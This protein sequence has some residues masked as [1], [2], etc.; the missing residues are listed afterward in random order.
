MLI[1]I[2]IHGV[3]YTRCRI[4]AHEYLIVSFDCLRFV[5]HEQYRWNRFRSVFDVHNSLTLFYWPSD[6]GQNSCVIDTPISDSTAQSKP[7]RLINFDYEWV[8]RFFL[9]VF[10]FIVNTV[11]LCAF[12]HQLNTR[13]KCFAHR[14]RFPLNAEIHLNERTSVFFRSL[15][16]QF[17][18]CADTID[19]LIAK[20]WWLVCRNQMSRQDTFVLRMAHF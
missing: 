1:S 3:R 19:L 13:P 8:T 11:S 16:Y 6:L 5:L 15:C 12:L 10:F 9:T 17:V 20:M 7:K 4:L 18:L 14:F 2:D